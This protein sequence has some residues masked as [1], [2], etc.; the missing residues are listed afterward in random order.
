MIEARR[1]SRADYWSADYIIREMIDKGGGGGG[2]CVY[3]KFYS[4]LKKK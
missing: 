1:Q 2:T 3:G 4:I